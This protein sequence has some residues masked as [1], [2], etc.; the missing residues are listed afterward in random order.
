MRGVYGAELARTLSPLYPSLVACS[1][2]GMYWRDGRELHPATAAI[3]SH[4]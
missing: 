1:A 3:E 4:G 2:W